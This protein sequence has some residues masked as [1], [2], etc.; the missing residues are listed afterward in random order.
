MYESSKKMR[1]LGLVL[2][3]MDLWDMFV[4]D[5]CFMGGG[6]VRGYLEDGW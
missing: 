2:R 6:W 4:K 3:R 1:G 5:C